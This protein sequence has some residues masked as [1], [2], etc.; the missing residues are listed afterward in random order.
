MKTSLLLALCAGGLGWLLGGCAESTL[1]G[2]TGEYQPYRTTGQ[3]RL[4][5]DAKIS[6]DVRD[7][8]VEDLDI[9]NLGVDVA[10]V[11][12]VVSLTGWVDTPEQK[13]W[14]EQL[15]ADEP[16]VR[17]VQNEIAIK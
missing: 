4:T 9:R 12:G 17:Q 13:F 14:A 3:Y 11:N 1:Q 8:L 15:A 16:G 2:R 5:D 7:Q 6:A 10:T